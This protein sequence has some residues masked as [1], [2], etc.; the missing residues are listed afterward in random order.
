[1]GR[2][3]DPDLR[4]LLIYRQQGKCA[5]CGQELGHDVEVDHIILW[6]EGGPTILENLQAIHPKCHQIKTRSTPGSAKPK[7]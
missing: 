1:M 3:V 6:A 5:I 4:N 2:S 7:S